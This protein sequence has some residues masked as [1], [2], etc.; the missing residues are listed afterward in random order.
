[1]SMH[2]RSLLG[3]FM[4]APLT[5]TA[6]SAPVAATAAVK[7]LAKDRLVELTE[8]AMGAAAYF[9]PGPANPNA[10]WDKFEVWIELA[11]NL[12]AEAVKYQSPTFLARYDS[13]EIGAG[14]I[15]ETSRKWIDFG[16]LSPDE[17]RAIDPKLPYA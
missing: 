5:V 9:Q 8:M 14:V 13:D 3:F 17:V 16:T 10:D 6:P 2:R 12:A 7:V 1:M 15:D 11:G 4:V